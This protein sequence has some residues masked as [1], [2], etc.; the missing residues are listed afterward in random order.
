[1][2][3]SQLRTLAALVLPLSVATAPAVAQT[4][5]KVPQPQ[6][7]LG[8]TSFLDGEAGRG[9]LAEVVVSGGAGTEAQDGP[10]KVRVSSGSALLH[11]AYI[12][13]IRIAGGQLGGEILI[14]IVAV[15]IKAA[16]LNQHRNGF[17]DPTFAPFVQWSDLPLLGTRVSVRFAVQVV[18]PFGDYARAN[19]I[20]I[21]QNAWQLS[22]YLAFTVRP[23]KRWEISG[24]AIY[25]WS[26]RN[27][28][29]AMTYRA[30]TIQAGDAAA[31]NLAASYEALPDLHLGISGYSYRQLGSAR[32]GAI[33]SNVKHERLTGI[34]PGARWRTK[35]FDLVVN[36]YGEF[37][38]RNRSAGYSMV[39]RVLRPL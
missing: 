12:S 21:G 20:N 13:D 22:P 28:D 34:G 9:A 4:A 3:Y 2:L 25:D 18:A 27:A 24:R 35:G 37:A 33:T 1:M 30:S 31:L 19:A 36:G 26:G 10:S 7:D 5:L 17:G 6:V 39:L 29:P 32:V 38:A 15:R 23:R 16:G 11:G 14:P 8:Q